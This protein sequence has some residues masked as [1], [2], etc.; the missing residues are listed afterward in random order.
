MN[1]ILNEIKNYITDE[2]N[3]FVKKYN[4]LFYDKKIKPHI[5]KIY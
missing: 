5:I 4:I 1:G 3:S 2:N